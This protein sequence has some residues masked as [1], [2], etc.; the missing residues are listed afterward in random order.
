MNYLSLNI[1]INAWLDCNHPFI[2]LHNKNDG[3][4][5][6][7]F[8]ADRVHQL[9]SNGEISVD[10][11]HST[12]VETQLDTISTLLKLNSVIRIKIYL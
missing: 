2:A 10:D 11:L 3:D 6:A 8:D 7:F 1:T 9:I 12:R 5:L 4:L